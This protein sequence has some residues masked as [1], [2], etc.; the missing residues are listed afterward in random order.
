M[1]AKIIIIIATVLL[2]GGICQ[3]VVH[4]SAT[5]RAGLPAPSPPKGLVIK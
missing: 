4:V 5:P 1:K 2:I 3:A